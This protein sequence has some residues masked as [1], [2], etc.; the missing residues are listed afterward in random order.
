MKQFFVYI[1]TNKRY[2]VFYVG[3]TSDLMGRIWQHREKVMKGFSEKYNTRFLVYYEAH[4][5]AESA[6]KREKQL[7]RWQRMWKIELIEKMN[8][9]WKDLALDLGFE[10]VA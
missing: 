4:E 9:T 5:S 2:G 6:I 3:V 7:K 1:L 10:A 8:P